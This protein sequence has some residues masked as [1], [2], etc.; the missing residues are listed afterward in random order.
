MRKLW[1]SLLLAGTF[2][3]FTASPAEARIEQSLQYSKLQIFN[4]SLRFLRV[5]QGYTI[6]EKDLDSGYLLFEY[7][8]G[9]GDQTT[10]G[11]VE[12]IEREGEI[13]LVLQ[14]PQ[15]PEHHERY[16]VD[17]LLN[18]LRLDYGAP[19]EKKAPPSRK[20]QKR[21]KEEKDSSGT[22]QREKDSPSA[23]EQEPPSLE[24]IRKRRI[25]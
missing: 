23:E 7:P 12:V 13:A 14:L 22:K 10:F 6:T 25:K 16:L 2:L 3:C 1:S 24:P 17:A 15:M 9:S 11:S 18:K 20:K 5:N 4:G 21:E 19:P 8:S